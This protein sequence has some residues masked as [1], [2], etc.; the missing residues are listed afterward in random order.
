[1]ACAAPNTDCVVDV[2]TGCG[3]TH[4]MTALLCQPLCCGQALWSSEAE[5][6]IDPSDLRLLKGEVLGAGS[7]GR[8]LAAEYRGTKVW[9]GE[10]GGGC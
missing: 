4:L 2:Q 1:M 9:G 10:W 5:W 8:V 7:Y 6:E 3:Y